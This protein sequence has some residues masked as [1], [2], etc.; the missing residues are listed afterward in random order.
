METRK[1]NWIGHILSKNWLLQ[2]VVDGQIK[3]RTEVTGR[4]GRRRNKLLNRKG[5]GNSKRKYIIALCGELAV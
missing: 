5:A 4:Q 1:A 2:Y 3:G